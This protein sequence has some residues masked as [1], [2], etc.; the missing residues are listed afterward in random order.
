MSPD[1][2]WVHKD[3]TSASLSSSGRTE[4]RGIFRFVQQRRR[5]AQH[6]VGASHGAKRKT[7][8]RHSEEARG[9]SKLLPAAAVSSEESEQDAVPQRTRASSRCHTRETAS[10]K[11]ASGILTI[12]PLN[13][14][15]SSCVDPFDSTI[16]PITKPIEAIIKYYW[17]M[18]LTGGPNTKEEVLPARVRTVQDYDAVREQGTREALSDKLALAGMLAS[19][20]T[21]IVYMSKF[22]LPGDV[23]PESYIQAAIS[24]LRERLLDCQARQARAEPA[25]YFGIWR[26]AL[27]ECISGY[28][29]MV[30]VHLQAMKKLLGHLEN[31]NPMKRYVNVGVG[32]ID[33]FMAVETNSRAFVLASDRRLDVAHDEFDAVRESVTAAAR[34]PAVGMPPRVGIQRETHATR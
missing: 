11:L 14:R 20:S 1:F 31:D 15:S 13:L 19:M 17:K 22:S 25:L 29:D 7:K 30:K 21:R 32:T 34:T 5:A 6:D 2:L 3:E 9:Q 10:P 16:T 26:L 12:K 24:I 23:R 8:S 27:A 33:M 4:T 28:F 18:V